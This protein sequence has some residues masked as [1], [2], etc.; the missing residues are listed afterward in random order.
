MFM[1]NNN[2]DNTHYGHYKYYFYSIVNWLPNKKRE[3]ADTIAKQK[4]CC[5]KIKKEPSGHHK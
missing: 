3:S 1:Y 5:G 4:T 2:I